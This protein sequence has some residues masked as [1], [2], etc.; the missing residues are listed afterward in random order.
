[1]AEPTTQAVEFGDHLT[2]LHDAAGKPSFGVISRTIFLNT[3][4]R[5]QVSDQQI[6]LYHKGR[7]DPG[8]VRV[9]VLIALCRFYGCQPADLGPVAAA[10]IAVLTDLTSSDEP[11]ARSGWFTQI[12][13]EA[14]VQEPLPL[15]LAG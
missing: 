9:E 14:W 15:E 12:G 8:G 10:E 2:A 6:G 3:N 1:M 5:V 7:T 13:G 4:G 11:F